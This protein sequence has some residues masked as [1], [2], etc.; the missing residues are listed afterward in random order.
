MIFPGRPE[1]TTPRQCGLTRDG[2]DA[3]TPYDD[4]SEL[5]EDSS[6]GSERLAQIGHSRIVS[7]CPG[8]SARM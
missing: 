5:S 1:A 3:A 4:S 2:A 6:S 8:Q 7:P